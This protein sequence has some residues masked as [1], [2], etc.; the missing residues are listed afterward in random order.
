MAIMKAARAY[1]SGPG[2]GEEFRGWGDEGR[3]PA[4]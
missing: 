3:W 4:E 2:P 1:G